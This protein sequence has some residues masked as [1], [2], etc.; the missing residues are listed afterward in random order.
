MMDWFN[1]NTHR[2]YPLVQTPG[3]VM[4]LYI[5]GVF[6]DEE[7]EDTWDDVFQELWTALQELGLPY[8]M[9]ADLSIIMGH[10]ARFNDADDYVYLQSIV[11]DD[12]AY[13][14]TFRTTAAG[15]NDDPLVFVVPDT[16]DEYTTVHTSLHVQASDMPLWEG[17]LTIGNIQA[18][19]ILL[20]GDAELTTPTD[21]FRVEPALIQ[22]LYG[23]H[24][25]NIKLINADRSRVA[26]VEGCGEWPE[27]PAY[28]VAEEAI[29]GQVKFKEGFNCRIY[30]ATGDNA[31]VF[32]ATVGAGMGEPT[33]EIQLFDGEAPPED[34][35]L[36]TGGPRCD[37]V[38]SS[39]NGVY[40][41][42]VPFLG[43]TGVSIAPASDLEHALVVNI[44]LSGLIICE[45]WSSEESEV[46]ES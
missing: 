34:S 27:F 39:I 35:Q 40:G 12:D 31:L 46:P 10:H 13:V 18:L 3:V 45:E 32:A 37:E 28:H 24:V 43:G 8:D 22:N 4:E 25:T 2:S 14:I 42:I 1:E 29:T 6:L 36:L 26:Y 17:W 38:I 20:V 30:T 15:A 41:P 21:A 5:G 9:L 11:H 23:S 16:A 33:E 19:H 44:T 7:Q